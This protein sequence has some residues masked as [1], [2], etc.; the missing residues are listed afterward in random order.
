MHIFEVIRIIEDFKYVQS[1]ST[2]FEIYPQYLLSLN[3]IAIVDLM[4][5]NF[6]KR[7]SNRY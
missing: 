7:M 6:D 3:F 1:T 2:I 4:V 5:L